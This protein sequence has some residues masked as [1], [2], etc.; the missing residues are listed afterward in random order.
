MPDL[1]TI[2]IALFFGVVGGLAAGDLLEGVDLG[3]GNIIAGGTG[4][5]VGS[6]V[7]QFVFPALGSFDDWFAI[8]GQVV[9]AFVS[10]ALLTIIVGV[11]QVARRR[12]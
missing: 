4:G 2:A 6:L 9:A 8:L 1:A 11:V 3:I 10:G 12:H 5:V 7:L